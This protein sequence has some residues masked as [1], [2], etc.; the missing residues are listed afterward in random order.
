M[1]ELTAQ[2]NWIKTRKFEISYTDFQPAITA[3]K[4]IFLR[5]ERSRSMLIYFYLKHTQIFAGAGITSVELFLFDKLILSVPL[6]Q[7]TPFCSL[8]VSDIVSNTSGSQGSPPV[9]F[10]SD[11][12]PA[13]KIILPY[14]CTAP[15]ITP[16]YLV[17]AELYLT[18]QLNAGGIINNLVSG[19]AIL[20]YT[21]LRMK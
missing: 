11:L 2:Y 19:S 1:Q 21:L 17:P 5:F 3:E 7:L 16:P 13:Q 10:R 18:I 20:F 9:R 8:I 4:S 15:P 12:I 14:E 6:A